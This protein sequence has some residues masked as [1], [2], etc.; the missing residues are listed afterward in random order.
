MKINFVH[1]ILQKEK[2][3]KNGNQGG[4]VALVINH[5]IQEAEAG[6]SV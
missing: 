6:I 4:V 1:K 2:E 5:D 3:R